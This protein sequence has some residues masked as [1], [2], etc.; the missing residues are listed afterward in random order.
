MPLITAIT[1]KLLANAAISASYQ[2]QNKLCDYRMEDCKLAK[3]SLY[4]LDVLCTNC[5]IVAAGRHYA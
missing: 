4:M 5:S 1:I 2:Q 3:R